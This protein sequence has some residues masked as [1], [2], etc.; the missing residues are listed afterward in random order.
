MSG[1]RFRKPYTVPFKP[2]RRP[3]PA[4][5]QKLKDI[6]PTCGIYRFFN[7]EGQILYIGKAVNLRRRVKQYFGSVAA[8]WDNRIRSMVPGINDLDWICSD[9]ELE[10]LL[11]E[12]SLIKRYCPD[13]NTRQKKFLL[14][15]YL[16][17]SND[18]FP[19]FTQKYRSDRTREGTT[20][21]PLTDGYYARDL[22]ESVN[23]A[24]GLRRCIDPTPNRR[25]PHKLGNC[26][27]PCSGLL[28]PEDY[29]KAVD[30]AKGFLSG[31]DDDLLG[32]VAEKM[33]MYSD[34]QEYLHAA[35]LRDRLTFCRRFWKRQ[36][37]YHQFI[38]KR[39]VIEE[40]P[41]RFFLFVRGRYRGCWPSRK[42]LEQAFVPQEETAEEESI[43][44]DRALVV[45]AWLNNRKSEKNYLFLPT[46]YPD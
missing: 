5:K 30:I 8:G 23:T 26:L 33:K 16:S 44:F 31:R 36:H 35:R 29:R 2:K 11:L 6:P 42:E 24:L 25:C 39:L 43:L 19:V 34:R 14:H 9:T 15:A 38:R 40:K 10:A 3:S 41:G 1:Q 7:R 20:F 18:L 27:E 22:L 46:P 45:L 17:L 32:I 28:D 13:F 4:V 21:G 37:F 12:D